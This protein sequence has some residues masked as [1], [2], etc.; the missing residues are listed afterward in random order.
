MFEIYFN[1][2]QIWIFEI[3]EIF[4]IFIFDIFYIW[5]ISIL[6]K[7]EY[8]KYLNIWD[9]QYFIINCEGK[10]FGKEYIYIH[11][12][13]F[14]YIFIYI[15]IC[16]NHFIVY[17][18]QTQHCKSIMLLKNHK[19]TVFDETGKI[20]AILKNSFILWWV[21]QKKHRVTRE[22]ITVGCSLDRG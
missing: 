18:K 3:F 16:L 22:G 12:Y 7:F 5:Y 1:I 10:V 4:N 13:I 20:N 14:I 11:I 6:F 21:L 9:I 19:K 15:Y 17:L 2:I 8:L